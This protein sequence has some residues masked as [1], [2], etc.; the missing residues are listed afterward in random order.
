MKKIMGI[1]LSISMLISAL[2]QTA[3]WAADNKC[4]DN[5]TWNLSDDGALTINGTGNMYDYSESNPSPW[6]DSINKLSCIVLEEGVTSVGSYAFYPEFTTG[7]D[8]FIPESLESIGDNAFIKKDSTPNSAGGQVWTIYYSGYKEDFSNITIGNGNTGIEESEIGYSKVRN[9]ISGIGQQ[10]DINN[11][12]TDFN[13]KLDPDGTLT[14]SGT[15]SM[16]FEKDPTLYDGDEG[17]FFNNA[18]KK[19]IVEEGITGISNFSYLAN[20]EEVSLPSTLKSIS[21]LCFCEDKKLKNIVIPDGTEFIE[22]SAFSRTGIEQLTIPESVKS[23]ADNIIIDTPLYTNQANWTDGALYISNWLIDTKD[24][25]TGEFTVKPGTVGI[26]G[27]SIRSGISSVLL[28]N[29]IKYLGDLAFQNYKGNEIIVPSGTLEI[30]TSFWFS[31]TKQVYI[32]KTVTYVDG[33]AFAYSGIKDIYYE[34]SEEEWNN[35]FTKPEYS[36]ELHAAFHFD[37]EMPQKILSSEEQDQLVLTIGKT[38]ASV[39]GEKMTND[40]APLI[41]NDRTML[42]ARFVAENLG[43]AVKWNEESR[44]VLITGKKTDGSDITIK[45]YIN[46]DTA[47]VNNEKITLDSPAF[48]EN[49]RT[50]TP[51]RFIA[52]QLGARVEW[53]ESEQKVIITKN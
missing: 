31:N 12:E 29:T 52:E 33:Y 37:A 26:A 23:I 22:S 40:V 35:I 38:D 17:T 47:Y 45:I 28:P 27:N 25:L 51:V 6:K 3:V 13:W 44:E 15:G 21:D 2:P 34:G 30:G 49:D 20:L 43:A 42:P 41:R 53:N 24:D 46:S 11:N 50:Y 16:E 8:L 48:I 14:V 7:I 19:I 1:A 32:P 10:F 18:V 36:Y 39:F 5:L 9:P 4:G